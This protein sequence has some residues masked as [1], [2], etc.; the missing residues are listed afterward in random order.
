[1]I[2]AFMKELRLSAANIEAID[3]LTGTLN[4]DNAN[5]FLQELPHHSAASPP[6]TLAS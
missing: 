2:A 4:N 1:M 6:H 5:T 3:W